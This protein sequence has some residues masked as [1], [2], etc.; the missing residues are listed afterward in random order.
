MARDEHRVAYPIGP[1]NRSGQ[2]RYPGRLRPRFLGVG[3]ARQ[4]CR[5][6]FVRVARAGEILR[7]DGKTARI[8]TVRAADH[9]SCAIRISIQAYDSA[10]GC[11]KSI[12]AG[13]EL[14]WPLPEI[15]M[16]SERDNRC[17]RRMLRGPLSRWSAHLISH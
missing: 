10:D 11:K 2:H 13:V 1:A 9:E 14:I 3:A 5:G 7:N 17:A 15:E 16:L 8:L 6:N 12:K 4:C